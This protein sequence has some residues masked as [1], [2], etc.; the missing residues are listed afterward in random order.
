MKELDATATGLMS[1]RDIIG[2]VTEA[3]KR[4]I[5][6][7]WVDE[8]NLTIEEQLD[9]TSMGKTDQFAFVYMYRL[10]HNPNLQNRKRFR[11][12]PV[13]LNDGEDFSKFYFWDSNHTAFTKPWIKI[14]T[15]MKLSNI[16]YPEVKAGDVL[17]FPSHMLHGVSP[18][19]SDIIRKTFSFNV[20]VTNVE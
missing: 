3:V 4:Y 15:Q 18:H 20:I 12:A 7:G 9:K 8:K 19:N 13:F 10:A 11:R 16:Y 6:D 14:L 5:K 17:L 1:G 2:E